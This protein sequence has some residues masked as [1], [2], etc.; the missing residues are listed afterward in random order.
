MPVIKDKIVSTDEVLLSFVDRFNDFVPRSVEQS[1][2]IKKNSINSDR[3]LFIFNAKDMSIDNMSQILQ[4]IGMTS[5]NIEKIKQKY[6]QSCQIG[7]GLE[8]EDNKTNYRAYIQNALS[9]TEVSMLK[10]KKIH[11]V[12]MIYSIKWNESDPKTIDVSKY[13]YQLN[14]DAEARIKLIKRS[15]L[16]FVPEALVAENLR[17][18]GNDFFSKNDDSDNRTA[19]YIDV[20][21]ANQD[22]APIELSRDIFD[23]T[24]QNLEEV[25]TKFNDANRHLIAGGVFNEEPFITLYYHIK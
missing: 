23:F 7:I 11:E 15:G 14:S 17:T 8:K 13:Y 6:T 25:L 22:L 2:K 12:E 19:F 24:E 16:G 9:M 1:I 5:D 18:Y 3:I 20:A 21:R 10:A 4:D